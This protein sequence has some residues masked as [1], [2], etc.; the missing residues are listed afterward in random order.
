DLADL[1]M[2]A[3]THARRRNRPNRTT[4]TAPAPTPAPSPSSVNRAVW[5]TIAFRNHDRARAIRTALVAIEQLQPSY[6]K[7]RAA[8]EKASAMVAVVN[9]LHAAVLAR[10]LK[11]DQLTAMGIKRAEHS[12]SLQFRQTAEG[13]LL[14]I[15][16]DAQELAVELARTAER[17]SEVEGMDA[18]NRDML[19]RVAA[20]F[21]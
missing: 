21:M 19:A 11:G 14:T 18:R 13:M 20:L 10:L 2:E 9:Q 7:I 8:T 3:S 15:G 4:P 6:K 5:T 12:V 17:L 16:D 1:K